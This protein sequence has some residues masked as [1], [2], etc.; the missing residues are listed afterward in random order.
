MASLQQAQAQV[1][2]GE[3]FGVAFV[4]AVVV[5]QLFLD[6]ADVDPLAQHGPHE[7]GDRHDYG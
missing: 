7:T 3:A 5:G 4:F 2:S 6:P 1:M